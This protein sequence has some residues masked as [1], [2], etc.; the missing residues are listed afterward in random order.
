[1]IRILALCLIAAISFALP[2]TGPTL[3]HTKVEKSDPADGATVK[4]GLTEL[5]LAFEKDIRL[6]LISLTRE[7]SD[8]PIDPTSEMPS[9]FVKKADITVEALEPG[10]YTLS[11]TGVAKDGHVVKQELS[12]TVEV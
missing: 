5:K 8:D 6:T 1:M 9:G 2:A 10:E 3:A 11:W 7:G 12:F 4:A